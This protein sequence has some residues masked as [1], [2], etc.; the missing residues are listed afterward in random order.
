MN[1]SKMYPQK[2]QELK[3]IDILTELA[4]EKPFVKNTMH[5]NIVA[6]IPN[7]NVN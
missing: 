1:I 7:S 4:K 2:I 5:I 6:P 3:V